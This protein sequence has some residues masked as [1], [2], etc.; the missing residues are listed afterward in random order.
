MNNTTQPILDLLER[1]INQRPGFE[2]ANYGSASSYRQDYSTSLKDKHD[3][4]TLLR[5]VRGS[6]MDLDTLKGGFR[7]FSGRLTLEEKGNGVYHLSYCTGQY[8][9]TEYRAAACAVLAAAL[10][11]YYREDFSQREE[12]KGNAIRAGFRRLFGKRIQQ[13][14][15]N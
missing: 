5:W 11:D 12:N 3:A 13:R 4:L 8:F 2:W 7:A 9:P 1:F 6:Q 14:W 15:F 10:W